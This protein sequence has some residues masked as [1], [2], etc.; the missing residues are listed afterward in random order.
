[1]AFSLRLAPFLSA[2]DSP[3]PPTGSSAS[4]SLA[5]LPSGQVVIFRYISYTT[6]DRMASGR[7]PEFDHY[8]DAL[9]NAGLEAAPGAG[10]VGTRDEGGSR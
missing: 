8:V 10:E 1:L 9:M 7:G 6:V 4:P 2:S 5:H 3:A